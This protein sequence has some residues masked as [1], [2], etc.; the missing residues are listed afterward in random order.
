M[1]WT[2]QSSA[3]GVPIPIL[4]QPVEAALIVAVD[5]NIHFPTKNE[6]V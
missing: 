5:H 6:D 3:L 1:Y 4:D 2:G